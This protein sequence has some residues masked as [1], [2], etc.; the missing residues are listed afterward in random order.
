MAKLSLTDLVSGYAAAA[1]YNAN[2]TL[3]E[4]ALENTL[5]RDGT[6]PNTMSANLD[7]NSNKITNL[8][9]GTNN[10]DAVTYAQLA[11]ASLASIASVDDLSDVTIT[12]AASGDVLYYN[13]SAWVDSALS[14]IVTEAIVEGALTGITAFTVGNYVFNVDQTVGAGQDNYVLTYDHGTGEIGLEAAAGGGGL[15]NVV[16]DVTPQLGGNLDLNSQTING[17]GTIGITGAIT[18]TS[19]G[20]ITEANLVDKSAAETVSG[21]WTMSGGINMADA[22][23]DRP[24]LEDYGI[25]STSPSSSSGAI[26]LDLS[27]G[28]S[29]QTTLTENIT[30]IT[31]SNPPASGTY[32]EC[33]WKITQ[34]ASAYTVTF[35][36]AVLWPDGGTAPTISTTNGDVDI[37]VMR[38]W[39]AGTTWYGDV[40]QDYA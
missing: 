19:Y 20:G 18:A 6:S 12:S 23:L 11:A 8:T 24:K 22:T 14:T 13:G 7:M 38:T 34:G 28:N 39:D 33:I 37:V 1:A 25:T 10:Q 31:L 16:E 35:P 3:I 4:A 5:S 27:A 21:L 2:N 15:S 26:T 36:A 29:F 40:G 30:S 17:T 32:G 9:D